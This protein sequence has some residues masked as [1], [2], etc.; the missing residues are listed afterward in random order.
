MGTLLYFYLCLRLTY[1]R[2]ST[3]FSLPTTVSVTSFKKGLQNEKLSPINLVNDCLPANEL[4][5]DLEES[6]MQISM[7]NSVMVKPVFNVHFKN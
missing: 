3:F 1:S 4:V 2:N 7:S 5:T 6:H